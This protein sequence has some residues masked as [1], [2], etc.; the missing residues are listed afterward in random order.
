[1]YLFWYLWLYVYQYVGYW[2][3]VFV[4][5]AVF[6]PLVTVVIAVIGWM[7]LSVVILS[8]DL[9]TPY[10]E[11]TTSRNRSLLILH[12]VQI[13]VN[14]YIQQVLWKTFSSYDVSIHMKK[15]SHQIWTNHVWEPFSID[16]SKCTQLLQVSYFYSTN[17]DCK[18]A[19]WLNELN[20]VLV[21]ERSESMA[22]GLSVPFFSFPSAASCIPFCSKILL[23]LFYVYLGSGYWVSLIA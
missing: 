7:G 20:T 18:A 22:G 4:F 23:T 1:M 11:R 21:L 19:L 16:C 14:L 10:P 5:V 9:V 15:W 13:S 6:A 2:L 8:E 17:C 12:S 3:S